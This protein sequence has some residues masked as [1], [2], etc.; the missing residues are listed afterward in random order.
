MKKRLDSI[1]EAIGKSTVIL[2]S[3]PDQAEW[4]KYLAGNS[5]SKGAFDKCITTFGNWIENLWFTFGDGRSI[6]DNINR[7]KYVLIS[8]R[9][10]LQHHQDRETL[11]K[12]LAHSALDYIQNLCGL[13]KFEDEIRNYDCGKLKEED[14]KNEDYLYE[15][16]Q[17]YYETLEEAGFIEQSHVL[18]NI[19]SHQSLYFR[20]KIS[21]CMIQEELR[22]MQQEEFFTTC[23]ESITLIPPTKLNDIVEDLPPFAL[24]EP[25]GR[26][27]EAALIGDVIKLNSRSISE[28]KDN[29]QHA[30][31]WHSIIIDNDPRMIYDILKKGLE[32]S[33]AL[34]IHES[35]PFASTDLGRAFMAVYSIMQ[36]K[37][38]IDI[39]HCIDLISNPL[40]GLSHDHALKIITL[41]EQDRLLQ[42]PEYRTKA[43]K[44]LQ[45]KGEDYDEIAPYFCNGAEQNKDDQIQ[46]LERIYT[47]NNHLYE[48]FSK[49]LI[50]LHRDTYKQ[51]G[52]HLESLK[53]VIAT[54]FKKNEK[55][56]QI[57]LRALGILIETLIIYSDSACKVDD[58]IGHL[59]QCSISCSSVQLSNPE[60][61]RILFTTPAK[62]KTL[63]PGCAEFV[64]YCNATSVNFP[65]KRIDTPARSTALRLGYDDLYPLLQEFQ[66]D[67]I[68][69]SDLA[70]KK[71]YISRPLSTPEGQVSSLP[72]FIESI[73]DDPR[74]DI[75]KKSRESEIHSR[76]E[77]CVHH[78]DAGLQQ[79]ISIECEE[80]PYP[81]DPYTINDSNKLVLVKHRKGSNTNE[82]EKILSPS[83]VEALLECPYGWLISRRLG[84]EEVKKEFGHLEI[85]T[86]IHKVLEE[87]YK[88]FKKRH[89]EDARLTIETQQEAQSIFDKAFETILDEQKDLKIGDNR[90]IPLTELEKS[91]INKIKSD[92]IFFIE[93]EPDFLA[94]YIPT[95]FEY[96]IGEDEAIDY[97]GYKICGS[98]DRIDMLKKDDEEKERA[99]VIDYK[100][101]LSNDYT[102]QIAADGSMLEAETIEDLEE[103]EI[104]TYIEGKIQTLIYASI[105]QKKLNC[106]AQGSLYVSYNQPKDGKKTRIIHGA[107]RETLDIMSGPEEKSIASFPSSKNLDPYMTYQDLLQD[108]ESMILQ[109]LEIILG[110]GDLTPPNE[111]KNKKMCRYCPHF[112]CTY[113]G[114]AKSWA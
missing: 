44:L 113:R 24:L 30:H 71:T 46:L 45:G 35:I 102:P 111:S 61:P 114:N 28:T 72:A 65:M 11:A 51:N 2:V 19:A 107:R 31:F 64:Y 25:A 68:A 34:E 80:L 105:I 62:A 18:K 69:I 29:S 58:A 82:P 48:I 6:V 32:P 87:F 104:Q 89:G 59:E 20:S 110:D 4:V 99:V 7:S 63:Q 81:S 57:Q 8:A 22:T 47:G 73:L 96:R 55:W 103:I 67:F 91:K 112:Y 13:E 66:H 101:S 78:N 84:A 98:V 17:T 56:R 9:R 79:G 3:S 77:S 95:H 53:N 76:P 33:Y 93:H 26:R 15:I 10:V 36:N 86:F 50:S 70:C 108:T 1:K 74:L 92:L 109:R 14:K 106:E 37:R 88:E 21:L 54:S 41:F 5:C 94:P 60:V 16:I 97:A 75:D 12:N 83:S 42:K 23:K 90:L 100:G 39:I 43:I 52:A 38:S 85:G 49:C 27:A 40:F